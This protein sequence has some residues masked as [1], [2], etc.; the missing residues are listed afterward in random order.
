MIHIALP[1]I[2]RSRHT[3]ASLVMCLSAFP[4]QQG[5]ESI[6]RHSPCLFTERGGLLL[7]DI[8]GASWHPVCRRTLNPAQCRRSM[9]HER[10]K[11]IFLNE[12]LPRKHILSDKSYAMVAPRKAGKEA[13]SASSEGVTDLSQEYDLGQVTACGTLSEPSQTVSVPLPP[14]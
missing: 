10:M 5:C 1:T 13:C 8:S 7:N 3:K 14:F 2:R 9:S 6:Q 12:N 11:R 4:S